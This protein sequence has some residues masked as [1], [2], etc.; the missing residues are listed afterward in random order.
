MIAAFLA[1]EAA[2][3]SAAIGGPW[4]AV[5]RRGDVFGIDA[6]I[7]APV[8]PREAF[9]VL[10]D[11]DAM[12][13]FVPNLES[14]R[15]TARDGDRL[16]VEQR[17]VARWGLLSHRFTTVRDVVLLPTESVTSSSVEGSTPRVQ[18]VTKFREV[19]GGTEVWHR[20]ELVFETWMPDFL[21]ERFLH[22][23]MNE[24]FE[25]VVAEMLRRR[26]AGR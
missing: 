11:F 2:A 26:A 8:T 16:R 25:A 20:V 21:A 12:A 13:G 10:T 14:S 17:G 5:S 3:A 6:V 15:V 19:P 7:I 9:D 23:E 24:Q 18:S 4:I 22:A 1:C